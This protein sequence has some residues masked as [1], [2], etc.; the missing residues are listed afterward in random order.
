MSD[1]FGP[2]FC[3]SKHP[4]RRSPISLLDSFDVPCINVIRDSGDRTHRGVVAEIA[5]PT[6]GHGRLMGESDGST[7]FT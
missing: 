6:K 1:Q 2:Y 5:G 4:G 3:G 7:V